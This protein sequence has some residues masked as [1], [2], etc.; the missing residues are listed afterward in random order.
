M[1]LY[2]VI[3]RYLL[4]YAEILKTRGQV[5]ERVIFEEAILHHIDDTG[6]KLCRPIIE[7]M[8]DVEWSRMVCFSNSI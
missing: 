2:A 5:G 1:R 4:R 7:Y 6:I 3:S 8:I